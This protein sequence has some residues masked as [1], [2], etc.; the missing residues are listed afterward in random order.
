MEV[1][2]KLYFMFL[3][4]HLTFMALK[5]KR[6]RNRNPQLIL[7]KSVPFNCLPAPEGTPTGP[8]G[9][10]DGGKLCSF[11]FVVVLWRSLVIL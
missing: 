10:Q 2:L 11:I 9:P 6:N 8:I 4:L 3:D 5:Y 1:S 7:L